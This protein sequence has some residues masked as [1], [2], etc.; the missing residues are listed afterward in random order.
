MP[1][2]KLVLCWE[3]HYY[4][5]DREVGRHAGRWIGC[6]VCGQPVGALVHVTAF[7]GM[8]GQ[9]TGSGEARQQAEAA[10][11]A[12]KLLESRP[13]FD[14]GRPSGRPRFTGAD[15]SSIAAAAHR[16]LVFIK[17]RRL[18]GHKATL[19]LRIPAGPI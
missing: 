12:A 3:Q 10:E 17:N 15:V 2:R 7:A 1:L 8:E 5:R 6:A 18:F 13:S 19:V 11:L 4:R 9:P 14:S 16:N